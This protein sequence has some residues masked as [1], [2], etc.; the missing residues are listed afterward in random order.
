MTL[1][2]L[3]ASGGEL[4]GVHIP[5]LSFFGVR[6]F[7]NQ[8]VLGIQRGAGFTDI[9]WFSISVVRWLTHCAFVFCGP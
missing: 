4:G 8:R 9:W 3:A 1:D 7:I 6:D 2:L 5:V